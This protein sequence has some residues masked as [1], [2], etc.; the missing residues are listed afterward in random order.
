MVMAMAAMVMAIP[1]LSR[2]PLLRRRHHHHFHHCCCHHHRRPF[3]RPPRFGRCVT[4]CCRC[5]RNW[6]TRACIRRCVCSPRVRLFWICA[7]FWVGGAGWVG[8]CRWAYMCV[9]T[10]LLCL[11]HL[12]TLA[13]EI[14]CFFLSSFPS[15]SIFFFRTRSDLFSLSLDMF[16]S[17]HQ[18]LIICA[19][20]WSSA[21]LCLMTRTMMTQ[22]VVNTMV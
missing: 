5:V 1:C 16:L 20:R 11:F 7:G 3:A 19:R 10:W 8:S 6:F 13:S 14:I 9:C 4:R 15:V 18:P 2:R 12:E 17:F 21:R 22:A